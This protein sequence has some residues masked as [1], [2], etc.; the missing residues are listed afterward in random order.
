MYPP[1]AHSGVMI[2]KSSK[3]L[4]IE[5]GA[6]APACSRGKYPIF[7]LAE[8]VIVISTDRLFASSWQSQ[9]SRIC[10]LTYPEA[11]GGFEGGGGGGF[12]DL[13]PGTPSFC[14]RWIIAALIAACPP[15]FG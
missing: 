9:Y 1:F 7:T 2:I 14:I 6:D 4:G 3:R 10:M 11:Y 15:V 8:S 5:A 12:A 13:T